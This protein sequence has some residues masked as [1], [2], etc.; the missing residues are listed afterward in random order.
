MTNQRRCTLGSGYG[1]PPDEVTGF[2]GLKGPAAP[3]ELRSST[4]TR[5][6]TGNAIGV[7][8]DGRELTS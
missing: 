6:G 8:V 1:P 5:G 2:N 4:Y 3:T 7:V